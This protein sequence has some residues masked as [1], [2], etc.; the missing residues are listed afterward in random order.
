MQVKRFE[1]YTSPEGKTG[2]LGF[3]I[4]GQLPGDDTRLARIWVRRKSGEVRHVWNRY[5]APVPESR[6]W[7]VRLH[8]LRGTGAMTRIDFTAAALK[9]LAEGYAFPKED[10][11][12]EELKAAQIDDPVYTLV[13]DWVLQVTA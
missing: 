6:E 2:D 4:T 5:L 11:A 10:P 3:K 12:L 13:K 1:L 9:E 8:L 7:E